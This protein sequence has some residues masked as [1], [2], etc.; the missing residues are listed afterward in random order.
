MLSQ[1]KARKKKKTNLPHFHLVDIIDV[2]S[3]R[4]CG[5]HRTDRPVFI[6]RQ[7]QSVSIDSNIRYNH[8]ATC[9]RVTCLTSVH[10]A[11]SRNYSYRSTEYPNVIHNR[12]AASSGFFINTCIVMWCRLM[13]MRA[14]R[15][16]ETIDSSRIFILFLFFC[17]CTPI[18]SWY[19]DRDSATL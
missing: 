12:F 1:L 18:H 10:Y 2:H 9:K 7:M 11:N 16:T 14:K 13:V 19:T 4:K 15:P 3:S 6:P 8:A 17:C 5:M